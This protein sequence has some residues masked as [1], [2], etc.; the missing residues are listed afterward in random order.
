MKKTAI[1][2]CVLGLSAFVVAQEK[3]SSD[4][5]KKDAP[6]PAKKTDATP[7]AEGKQ[8]AEKP[9]ADAE[10][11]MEALAKKLTTTDKLIREMSE[12]ALL[13]AGK[14]AVPTLNVL[15][16]GQDKPLADAAKKLVERIQRGAERPATAGGG[17]GGANERMEKL[18]KDLN[19][20]EKKTQK[21]KDLQTSARDR[22]REIM[23]S[24]GSGEM[25]REE[26]GAAMQEAREE[27]KGDLKKSGFS[28]EEIKKIEDSFRPGRGQ[29]GGMR[30]MG[31]GGG[32]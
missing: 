24:V 11:M 30:R 3:P 6:A 14:A 25:S 15:A 1:T 13:K 10:K 4:A 8:D 19:L 12:A 16:T 18:I 29:G 5:P 32:G 9:S 26:A 23:E 22:M 7:A 21:L 2:L 28:D 20:D 17:Q 27:M 31:G